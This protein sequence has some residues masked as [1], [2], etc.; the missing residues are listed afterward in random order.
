MLR[1]HPA[2]FLPTYHLSL[3]FHIIQCYITFVVQT[4]SLNNKNEPVMIYIHIYH[5]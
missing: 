1:P 2:V 5:K 3:Y 4:S